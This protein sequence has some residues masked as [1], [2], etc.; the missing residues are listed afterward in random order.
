[1]PYCHP[2]SLSFVITINDNRSSKSR[3]E[4]S[5]LMFSPDQPPPPFVSSSASGCFN[6]SPHDRSE[7]A[8]G[9]M[10]KSHSSPREAVETFCSRMDAQRRMGRMGRKRCPSNVSS[11][12]RH[13]CRLMPSRRHITSRLVSSSLRSFALA[14]PSGPWGHI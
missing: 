13:T 11:S 10:M 4:I 1:M 8:H 3:I 5:R 14:G 6:L 7:T 2:L 12:G 9:D